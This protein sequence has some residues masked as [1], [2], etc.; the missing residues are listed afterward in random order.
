MVPVNSFVK[1]KLLILILPYQ[2]P[3]HLDVAHGSDLLSS[4]RE[5]TPWLSAEWYLLNGIYSY[6]FGS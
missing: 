1:N 3:L 4:V 6:L 5:L 2:F